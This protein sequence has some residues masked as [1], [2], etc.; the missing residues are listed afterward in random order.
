MKHAK[1]FYTLSSGAIMKSLSTLFNYLLKKLAATKSAAQ[2]F[3]YITSLCSTNNKTDAYCG[4]HS[5]IHNFVSAI[6]GKMHKR[7]C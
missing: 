7:V 6:K 1:Y 4:I 3:K 2:Y 5:I